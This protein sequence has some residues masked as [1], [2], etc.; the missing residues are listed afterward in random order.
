MNSDLTSPNSLFSVIASNDNYGNTNII[1]LNK[2][3]NIVYGPVHGIMIG[4][5]FHSAPLMLR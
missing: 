1:E 3:K 2:S 4:R 5:A